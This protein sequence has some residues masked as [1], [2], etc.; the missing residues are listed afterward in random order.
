M[1]PAATYRDVHVF[2]PPFPLEKTIIEI[3]IFLTSFLGRR[4]PGHEGAPSGDGGGD[5]GDGGGEHA[6][7]YQQGA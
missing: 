2:S 5:G 6:A 7:E 3:R 4:C 1:T